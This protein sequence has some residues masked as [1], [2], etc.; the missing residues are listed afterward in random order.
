M[1][2]LAQEAIYAAYNEGLAAGAQALS[3]W[4]K[5]AYLIVELDT[6]LS[7]EGLLG[8]YESAVAQ[9]AAEVVDALVAIGAEESSRL[10]HRA[11]Q[12]LAV[13]QQA[14]MK[15]DWLSGE[16]QT[17]FDTIERL[18]SEGLSKRNELLE[19]YVLNALRK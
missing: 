8:F 15:L 1:N 5:S 19:I 6:Y 9:H 10:I 2:A 4:K 7:V 18:Y 17:E 12:L 3:D 11:N 14:P 13:T 16:Q